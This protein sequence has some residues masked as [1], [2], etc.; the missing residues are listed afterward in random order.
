MRKT[1]STASAEAGSPGG[2]SGGSSDV[3]PA[4]GAGFVPASALRPAP[5]SPELM[6][7]TAQTI[8]G[9]P[10]AQDRS[11]HGVAAL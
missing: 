10:G 2:G 6:I 9:E 1:G 3:E 4:A 5:W 8:R 7:V 11:P